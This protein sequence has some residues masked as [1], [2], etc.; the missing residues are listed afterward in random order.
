MNHLFRSHWIKTEK[1]DC[2]IVNV[3]KKLSLSS[4]AV[5]KVLAAPYPH[6][7]WVGSGICHDFHLPRYPMAVDLYH[8][9]MR[10]CLFVYPPWGD[11]Y[12]SFLLVLLDH[13]SIAYG[14]IL[15]LFVVFVYHFI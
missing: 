1:W 6:Q 13:L 5:F 7:Q 8:L 4:P 9:F 12:S 10:G 3:Y 15:H 14:K 2:W 11:V